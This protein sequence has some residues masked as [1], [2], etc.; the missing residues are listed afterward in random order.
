MTNK[1]VSR[2]L[3]ADWYGTCCTS[4]YIRAFLYT[5]LLLM[6]EI[7]HQLIGRLSLYLQG[8][9]FLSSQVV[10]DFF[11]QKYAKILWSAAQKASITSYILIMPTP[12]FTK[13]S[14]PFR[15]F[16]RNRI[17]TKNISKW[18]G[19]W[20]QP[21]AASPLGAWSRCHQQHLDPNDISSKQLHQ[22][23]GG[24]SGG[25]TVI[26]C[27]LRTKSSILFKPD[28]KIQTNLSSKSTFWGFSS[29]CTK[30]Y[31]NPLGPKKMV[32]TRTDATLLW[33]LKEVLMR[34]DVCPSRTPVPNVMRWYTCMISIW[35][36]IAPKDHQFPAPHTQCLRTALRDTWFEPR[37]QE[38][39]CWRNGEHSFPSTGWTPIIHP[40]RLTWNL[41]IH[42]WKRRI[43]FQTIIFRF[44]VNLR[45]CR[46]FTVELSTFVTSLTWAMR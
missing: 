46:I 9:R 37:L 45:G 31:I 14:P 26:L 7:L 10:Q 43:I 44:Y 16:N 40:E 18:L 25:T 13:A 5:N 4:Y 35:T 34:P 20:P 32:W 38:A 33:A 12:D 19:F 6:E 11:Y 28:P 17:A 30:S 24:G 42:P 39:D 8:P 3:H 21:F 23:N 41:R 29:C 1:F 36:S 15:C 2:E 27:P 22:V